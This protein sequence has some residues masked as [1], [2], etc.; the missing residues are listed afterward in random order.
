MRTP[1][2]FMGIFALALIL[3]LLLLACGGSDEPSDG[4]S[5]ER[6]TA[7]PTDLP[8]SERA[9]D[10]PES[11]ASSGQPTAGP[12][13]KSAEPSSTPRATAAP[14]MV[15]ISSETDR[16]ALI[17]L[18]N[19]T[20]GPQWGM[21]NNNWLSDV[22]IRHWTGVTTDDNGR[23]TKLV[24]S[25]Y[26]LSGEIPPEL[27]K[28]ANLIGLFLNGNQLSGCVP[29]SLSG[30]LGM[31]YSDLG[32]SGS[33]REAPAHPAHRLDA[34]TAERIG[35]EAQYLCALRNVRRPRGAVPWV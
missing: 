26:W 31:E 2:L 17:A 4:A 23:I 3:P 18:Y 1:R 10:E 22:P 27:G 21:I 5:S 29:S 12:T 13:T 24:L 9:T 30:R 11:R 15:Q 7:E 35:G 33:A 16:E 20:G 19:T 32:D 34:F 14:T 28:L 8:D 25:N 6:A